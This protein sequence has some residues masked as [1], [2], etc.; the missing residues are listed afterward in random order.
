MYRRYTSRAD[1]L[2]FGR[3]HEYK[4]IGSGSEAY[5][6]YITYHMSGCMGITWPPLAAVGVKVCQRSLKRTSNG[7]PPY[8]YCWNLA[9]GRWVRGAFEMKAKTHR[10]RSLPPI[11]GQTVRRHIPWISSRRTESPQVQPVLWSRTAPPN[12]HWQS[13][14]AA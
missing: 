5:E 3:M 2:F 6:A 4:D 9:V 11:L 12:P 14:M 13:T 7:R 10:W 1:P 8:M